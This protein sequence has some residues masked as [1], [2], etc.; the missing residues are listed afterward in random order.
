MIEAVPNG[1]DLEVFVEIDDQIPKN[2]DRHLRSLRPG[3]HHTFD[4]GDDQRVPVWQANCFVM[5][6]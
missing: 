3:G 6:T 4:A 5:E 1:G 2:I